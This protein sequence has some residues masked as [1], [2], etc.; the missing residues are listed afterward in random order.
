M[1]ALLADTVGRR[2]VFVFACLSCAAP[3][4]LYLHFIAVHN[5]TAVFVVGRVPHWRGGRHSTDR[6]GAAPRAVLTKPTGAFPNVYGS[7][8]V[9]FC[10]TPA[11]GTRFRSRS[12]YASA[13]S[14]TPAGL[15]P[16]LGAALMIAL[17]TASR[18]WSL[19]L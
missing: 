13:R 8:Q 16:T 4:W 1:W 19:R 10:T 9:L 15:L 3:M 7:C 12:A 18:A 6:A 5:V 14:R 2:P 17:R 11:L